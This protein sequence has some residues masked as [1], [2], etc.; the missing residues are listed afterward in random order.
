MLPEGIQKIGKYAF[1]N[2]EKVQEIMTADTNEQLVSGIMLAIGQ[3]IISAEGGSVIVEAICDMDSDGVIT[4]A[5]AQIALRR[6]LK[7][8]QLPASE[9]KSQVR[10]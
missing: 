10:L 6:A 7:L 4:L 9:V 1:W 2:L 8:V 3:R 5:D